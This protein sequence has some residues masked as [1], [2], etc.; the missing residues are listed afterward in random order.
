VTEP[1][2]PVEVVP[3]VTADGW[4]PP[5]RALTDEEVADFRERFAAAAHDPHHQLLPYWHLTPAEVRDLLRECVTVVK[6]GETLI[7]RVPSSLTPAQSREYQ[8][9]MDS[10]I[11]YWHLGFKALVLPAEGLGIVE[12]PP[13]D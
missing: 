2:T 6:P 1:L 5:S 13:G 4:I 3:G 8:D 9:A 12:A 11:D 7:V 10:A